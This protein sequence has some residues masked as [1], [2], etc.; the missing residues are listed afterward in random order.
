MITSSFKQCAVGALVY[1]LVLGLCAPASAASDVK[2]TASP[3]PPSAP[4]IPDQKPGGSGDVSVVAAAAI[5]APMKPQAVRFATVWLVDQDVVTG[6]PGP[7]K[8]RDLIYKAPTITSRAYTLSKAYSSGGLD[9]PAGQQMIGL[10]GD[11]PIACTP[12]NVK[13]SAMKALLLKKNDQRFCMLDMERDGKF[14]LSF[15]LSSRQQNT[16]ERPGYV[17]NEVMAIQPTDYSQLDP[18]SLTS[19]G[20]IYVFMSRNA[21]VKGVNIA[22]VSGPPGLEGYAL[23]NIY[24]GYWEYYFKTEEM[25][26]TIDVLNTRIKLQ[27]LIDDRLNLEILKSGGLVRYPNNLGQALYVVRDA[28]FQTITPGK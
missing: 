19:L 20:Y 10:E 17:P 5:P 22:I 28:D 12:E 7:L 9:F 2:T 3:S 8:N 24:R 6:N 18:R 25:P 23:G 14:E 13:R 15:W 21:L 26:L 11:R 1:S 16:L 27:S 4:T